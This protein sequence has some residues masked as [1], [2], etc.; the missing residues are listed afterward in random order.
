MSDTLALFPDLIASAPGDSR[1]TGILPSQ[2]LE[3]LVAA[4]YIRAIKAASPIAP[5]QIQ[6]SS[7]DLRLGAIGYEV[8]ASFLPSVNA[9]VDKKLQELK[10]KELDLSGPVLLEKGK[11]YIVPLQEELLLPENYSGKANP[12]SSIGRLGVFTRLI[13]DYGD[14]FEEIRTAYKGRL[15][16][17]IVPLTF[18][19]YVREGVTLNHLR[20]RRGNPR[21]FDKRLVDLHEQQPLVYSQ[22]ESP[23]EPLISDGLKLSVDLQ[24]IDGSEVI[25]YRAKREAAPIDLS[26]VNHYNPDDFWER[27]YRDRGSIVLEPGDFYILTSKEK[28]SVPP[29]MAA[30]MLPF[31]PAVGEFRIHYAGFFDPGFGWSPEK[32][33]GNHAVLEVRSHEVRSLLED[34]QVVGRLKYEP[35]LEQ[36]D[37]LYGSTATGSSYRTQSLTLSKHFKT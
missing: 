21:Q 2:R 31:D 6:A 12:K 32:T 4:G 26:F 25:G 14:A 3:D 28:V 33:I 16:A 29:H 23:A 13:T 24:G 7:I 37:K 17:E 22:D 30:E 19:V 35:L 8:C 27:I 36:P 1:T 18:E 9:T 11:V 5:S 10:L 15:Y 20:V 34:G